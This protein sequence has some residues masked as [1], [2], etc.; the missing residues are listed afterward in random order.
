M[1]TFDLP[2]GLADVWYNHTTKCTNVLPSLKLGYWL[3]QHGIDYDMDFR[4]GDI[5]LWEREYVP[6]ICIPDPSQAV[7]FKLT[8]L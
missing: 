8:W 3:E 5:T 7:L 2:R 6:L 1:T 4:V